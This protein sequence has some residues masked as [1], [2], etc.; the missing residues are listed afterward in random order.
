MLILNLIVAEYGD[1]VD[2]R[3]G[4]ADS[5]TRVLLNSTLIDGQTEEC[6]VYGFREELCTRRTETRVAD[7]GVHNSPTELG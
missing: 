5:L 3:V 7:D 2:L 4:V 1:K 6:G